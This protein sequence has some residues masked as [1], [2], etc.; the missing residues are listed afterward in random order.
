M[1]TQNMMRT[2]EGKQVFSDYFLLQVCD[3]S[4][5]KQMPESDQITNSPHMFR[6]ISE[7]PSYISNKFFIFR[8]FQLH[9]SRLY[10]YMFQVGLRIRVGFLKKRI[11]PNLYLMKFT[12]YFFFRHIRQYYWGSDRIRPNF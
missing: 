8:A 12:F 11:L 2:C 10:T 6:P 7:L 9:V 3:F 4:R 1:A 5:S